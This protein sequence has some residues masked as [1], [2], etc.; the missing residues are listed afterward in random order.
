VINWIDPMAGAILAAA[1]IPPL[2]LLYFLKLRRRPRPIASTLLWKKSIEDLRANAPFQKLRKN[3][4]LLLQLIALI[5]LALAIMQP[6]LQA[7]KTSGGRVIILIDNSASMNAVDGEDGMSRL[8]RAKEEAKAFVE[9]IQSSGLFGGTSDEVMVI[10]FNSRAQVYC[11]FTDSRSQLIRAI[12]SI[13]PT[14]ATTSIDEALKLARAH[15]TI[16]NPDALEGNAARRE[17]LVEPVDLDLFTDGRI[18]DFIDQVQKGETLRPHFLGE[19]EAD[20]VSFTSVAAERPYDDPTSIQVFAS[21]ANFNPTEVTATVQITVNGTIPL[22]GIRDVA[23]SAAEVNEATGELAP[24]RSNVIF[25]PFPQP[26]GAVIEVAN[27]REDDLSVDNTAWL[28][29]PPPRQLRV[30]FVEPGI[31]LLNEAVSGFGMLQRLDILTAAEFEAL[32]TANATDRYDVIALGSVAPAALPPGKYL[33]FAA[34]LPLEALSA[35]EPVNGLEVA[36]WDREHALLRYVN[37]DRLVIADL[38][39]LR[40]PEQVKVLAEA[41]AGM[42]VTPAIVEYAQDGRHILHLTFN[43]TDTNWFW[44][45]SFVIFMV[46]AVEYLGTLGEASAERDLAP[47]EPIVTRLPGVATDVQLQ[48]P[49]DEQPQE[50]AI[51][52]QM[53]ATWPH[54]WITGFYELTW[55]EGGEQRPEFARR[56]AVNL[57]NEDESRIQPVR[58]LKWGEQTVTAAVRGGGMQTPLWPWALGFC[59]FVLMLEW[60]VYHR[61][62]HL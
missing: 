49:L 54:T 15:T 42:I 10:G 34:D 43:P 29:T 30:A 33:S 6:Q 37:L 19:D 55:T 16:D 46:N 32:V 56:F 41:G 12:D 20:N 58:E 17:E 60:W 38:K 48:T 39:P 2:I 23:I 18:P 50:I 35:G 51:D 22:N 62:T 14:H 13:Q 25:G 7:G 27:L 44:N 53:T 28:I 47:G 21:L 57:M 8:D 11:N 59:L 52:E 31:A 45:S 4:L 9:S 3:L 36:D 24:G 40:N 5:L 1:V 26:Q 61:R